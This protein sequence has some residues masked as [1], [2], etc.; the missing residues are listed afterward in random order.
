MFTSRMKSLSARLIWTDYA[1][2][3][4]FATAIVVLLLG[5]PPGPV[6]TKPL[7][8]LKRVDSLSSRGNDANAHNL[9]LLSVLQQKSANAA[10]EHVASEGGAMQAR[11]IF[12]SFLAALVSLASKLVA[13]KINWQ[14]YSF[15]LFLIALMFFLDVLHEDSGQIQFAYNAITDKDIHQL[16]NNTPTD[17]LWYVLS[18]DAVAPSFDSLYNWPDRWVRKGRLA[19]QLNPERIIF[20]LLPWM[21]VYY[22]AHSS[23]PRR[24]SPP[25]SV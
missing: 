2:L 7:H 9:V 5:T 13:N 25:R 10:A 11:I 24:T 6:D 19:C 20:F 15:F 3:V 1:L 17:T 22:F 14:I 18:Y 8:I 16:A 4:L 21:L 23:F 12:S